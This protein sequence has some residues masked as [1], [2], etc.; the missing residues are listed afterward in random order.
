MRSIA[1]VAWAGLL[2]MVAV[3][4]CG[5]QIGALL[6]YATPEQKNKAD[7]KLSPNRLAIL[8]DDPYG[9]LPR[10]DLRAQIHAKLVAEMAAHKIQ[11]VVVPM[12]EMAKVEQ[13]NREFDKMSIRAVGEQ[14]H[15]D[16]VLYVSI[17]SFT[18]GEEAKHGVYLGKARAQVKICSTERKASV[19][20][21]PPSGDGYIVEI[22]QPSEQTEEWGNSKASELYS[23]VVAERLAKR[24]SLL[25]YEHSAELEDDLTA[26]RNERPAQ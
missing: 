11:A 16:Q 18:V 25:F 23:Q 9:S 26:G 24:I 17:L 5:Q 15:A 1:T 22:Q 12:A 10:S 6:Y 4:G 8:I 13:G 3:S 19:R 7:F 2:V 21:W 14:V 20:V